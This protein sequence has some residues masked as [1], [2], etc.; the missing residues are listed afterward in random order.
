MAELQGDLSPPR[1]MPPR[2]S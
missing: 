1:D 2:L